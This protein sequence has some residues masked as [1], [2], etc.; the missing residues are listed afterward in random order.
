MKI[1]TQ[2]QLVIEQGIRQV[3]KKYPKGKGLDVTDFFNNAKE[4]Y[5][6]NNIALAWEFWRKYVGSKNLNLYP[7]NSNDDTMKTALL[8]VCDKI[9]KDHK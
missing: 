6:E 2:N 4:V 7:C 1:D 9:F 3:L 5:R 8:K